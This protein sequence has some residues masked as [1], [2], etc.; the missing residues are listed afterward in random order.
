MSGVR[1]DI[2]DDLSP[3][4]ATDEREQL[5]AVG[6]RLEAARPTPS[7]GF[8]GELRRAVTNRGIRA[9]KAPRMTVEAYRRI[10]LACFAGGFLLLA[11]A[12]GGL[13]GAGPFSAS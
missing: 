6:E 13:A 1:R 12:A 11:V 9:V 5:A 8:R 2:R 7:P 3:D 10:V 4:L